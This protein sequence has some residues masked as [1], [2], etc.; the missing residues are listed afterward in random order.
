MKMHVH[1]C[2]KNEN[3]RSNSPNWIRCVYVFRACDNEVGTTNLLQTVNLHRVLCGQAKQWIIIIHPILKSVVILNYFHIN[4]MEKML[5]TFLI[6]AL[7]A[8][9]RARLLLVSDD[10]VENVYWNIN[11]TEANHAP[12]PA[13][14]YAIFSTAIRCIRTNNRKDTQFYSK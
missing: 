13:V 4:V 14:S 8:L 1:V 11:Q 10:L 9:E 3:S 6:N 5:N 2:S 12:F 7:L